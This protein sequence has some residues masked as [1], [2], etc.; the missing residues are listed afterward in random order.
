VPSAEGAKY[1]SLGHRP[2][3]KRRNRRNTLSALKA[4][5]IPKAQ[6][7]FSSVTTLFRAFSASR[8]YLTRAPGALPQAIAFRAFGAAS[9]NQFL[10]RSVLGFNCRLFPLFLL[11]VHPRKSA[12]NFPCF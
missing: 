11:R 10:P 2:S 7:S 5:N 6:Y 3:A 1:D 4:R 12:A 9:F 8:V